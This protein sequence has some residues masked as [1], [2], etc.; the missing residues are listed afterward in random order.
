[1]TCLKAILEAWHEHVTSLGE[2][3]D[4]PHTPI[5][6]NSKKQI[7]LIFE[8]LILNACVKKPYAFCTNK[9]FQTFNISF[10]PEARKLRN[11]IMFWKYSRLCDVIKPLMRIKYLTFQRC[12]RE[13]MLEKNAAVPTLMCLG[14]TPLPIFRSSWRTVQLF[15]VSFL[16]CICGTNTF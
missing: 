2:Q 16:L 10:M 6:R 14:T 9:Y 11:S 3:R 8:P 5:Y 13:K 7:M 15:F 1:M 12:L 4:D